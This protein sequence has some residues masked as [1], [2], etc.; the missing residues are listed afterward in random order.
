MLD[1]ARLSASTI[2]NVDVHYC[3]NHVKQYYQRIMFVASALSMGI[4]VAGC[5]KLY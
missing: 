1:D 5:K 4:L 2:M 3:R